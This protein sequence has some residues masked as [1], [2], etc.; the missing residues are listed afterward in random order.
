LVNFY[1]KN[2]LYHRYKNI[3]ESNYK[4]GVAL[5][6]PF[7][8]FDNILAEEI[9]GVNIPTSAPLVYEFDDNMKAVKHYYLMDEAE[10]KKQMELKS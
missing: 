10:L 7:K 3:T 8:I 4:K 2:F 6:I 9:I 1:N 5:H